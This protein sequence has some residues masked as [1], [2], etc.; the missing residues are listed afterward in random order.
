MKEK[1]ITWRGNSAR[2][3]SQGIL[4]MAEREERT[5]SSLGES[6]RGEAGWSKKSL[7]LSPKAHM[8]TR[9]YVQGV[10]RILTIHVLITAA[11]LIIFGIFLQLAQSL[12]SHKPSLSGL[13]SLS[14]ASRPRSLK[15]PSCL[16]YL[17]AIASFICLVFLIFP[18]CYFG[19]RGCL[20]VLSEWDI[21]ACW[22]GEG[23]K[24][25]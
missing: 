1:K 22:C 15:S 16:S 4:G 17:S 5:A 11:F 14:A 19:H 7:C 13:L 20:P 23:T 21:S 9:L 18:S 8:G 3:R 24:R 25:S 6:L 10:P 12:L 2:N